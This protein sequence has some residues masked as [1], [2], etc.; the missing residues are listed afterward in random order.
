MGQCF[1]KFFLGRRQS[2]VE[3]DSR[4]SSVVHVQCTEDD[5]Q[6]LHPIVVP[7]VLSRANE[8]YYICTQLQQ[9]GGSERGHFLI[10]PPPVN[11]ERRDPHGA[12]E[13]RS[14]AL[15]SERTHCQ[16]EPDP[17]SDNPSNVPYAPC[18]YDFR[19]SN[20]QFQRQPFSHDQ[21]DTSST[22]HCVQAESYRLCRCKLHHGGVLSYPIPT[23]L[24]TSSSTSSIDN[25]P[26]QNSTK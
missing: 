21:C 12:V 24:S 13:E 17:P 1:S 3:S 10:N 8:C 16:A 7:G 14:L 23:D 11:G 20:V 19:D 4:P 2:P 9:Q 22:T 5:S 15:V 25:H 26:L 6:A 18:N